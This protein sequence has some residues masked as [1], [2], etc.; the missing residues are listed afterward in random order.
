MRES[1]IAPRSHNRLSAF[2]VIGTYMLSVLIAGQ[3]TSS[4]N[5]LSAFGVIGTRIAGIEITHN[6]SRHNRL[7]AFGVIGTPI[8]KAM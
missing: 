7:S 6:H 1:R 4:H 2:G 8:S 3:N 5:R